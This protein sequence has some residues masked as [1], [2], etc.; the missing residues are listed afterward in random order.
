MKLI[1]LLTTILFIPAYKHDNCIRIATATTSG[2]FINEAHHCLIK[3]QPS[4]NA[5][6]IQHKFGLQDSIK[7]KT[8]T[9]LP[10]DVEGCVCYFYLSKSDETKRKYIMTEILAEIA[11]I[12]INGKMQRFYLVAFKDG[13]FYN[14]SNGN[15]KLRVEFKKTIKTDSEVFRIIGVLK[16]FKAQKLLI[17]KNILGECSC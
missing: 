3:K 11:Y 13:V 7:L 6:P 15:Y 2:S 8:F 17:K 5:I 12:F 14:Y 4:N 16:I 1:T 10:D 9:K